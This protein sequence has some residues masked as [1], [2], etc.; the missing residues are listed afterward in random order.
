LSEKVYG[1][2]KQ[3]VKEKK[4]QGWQLFGQVSAQWH[5]KWQRFRNPPK[6]WLT[7]QRQSSICRNTFTFP[8]PRC[9]TLQKIAKCSAMQKFSILPH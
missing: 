7:G 6:S 9:F 2:N 4:Q 1:S 5:F 3:H 8:R